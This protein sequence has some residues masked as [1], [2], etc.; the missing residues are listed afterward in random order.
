M[1]WKLFALKDVGI[2]LTQEVLDEFGAVSW[3]SLTYVLPLVDDGLV[4]LGFVGNVRIVLHGGSLW[5][6]LSV[7]VV[8]SVRRTRLLG[9]SYVCERGVSFIP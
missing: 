8:R 9:A 4:D 7:V 3:F 2:I 6:R 1:D 5:H